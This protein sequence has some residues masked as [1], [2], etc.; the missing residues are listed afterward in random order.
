[1]SLTSGM[2]WSLGV[3]VVPHELAADHE[4]GEAGH[5]LEPGDPVDQLRSDQRES[6]QAEGRQEHTAG[7]DWKAALLW[8]GARDRRDRQRVVELQGDVGERDCHDREKDGPGHV[9][10]HSKRVRVE[11][12]PRTGSAAVP[13]SGAVLT[14]PAGVATP[15]YESRPSI[16]LNADDQGERPVDRDQSPV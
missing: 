10:L 3:E 11:V 8:H 15:P 13:G 1:M 7:E 2:A 12:S 4:Q 16:C 9:K 6:E 14:G 5:R